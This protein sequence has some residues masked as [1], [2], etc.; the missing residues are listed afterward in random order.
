[1]KE[2][3]QNHHSRQNHHNRPINSY[4]PFRPR[5]IALSGIF[6]AF[7]I[8]A[9]YAES[10]APTGRLSLFALSSLFVSI[11]V[12]ESGIKAGWLFYIAS[13]LLAF[14]VVPDKLG[15]IP[16]FAF[17]GL[18]GLIKYYAEKQRLRAVEY[19]LKYMY[20]NLCLAL[21]YILFKN[22]FTDQVELKLPWWLLIAVLQIA[23]LLFDFVYSLFIQ[24]YR[25]R[26]RKMIGFQ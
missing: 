25:N 2:N 26:I 13:S 12:V 6:L 22:L 14:L 4:K 3:Q 8:I 24:F 19:A 17:F 1:M 20:F 16:Y 11:I 7:T 9:L 10:L 23:F 5:V 21:A 18:F 15:L